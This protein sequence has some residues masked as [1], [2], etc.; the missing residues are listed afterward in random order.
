MITYVLYKHP[1]HDFS[2]ITNP[3]FIFHPHDLRVPN[4]SLNLIRDKLETT[5]DAANLEL[6]MLVVNGPSYLAAIAGML[7][8][9]QENR[10]FYNMLAYNSDTRAYE[11]HEERML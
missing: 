2:G 11:M 3:C 6:D 1:K 5:L 9:T 10:K 7:W 4:I 8:L